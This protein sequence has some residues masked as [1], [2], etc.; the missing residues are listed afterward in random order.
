MPDSG[1]ASPDHP[2]AASA[3]RWQATEVTMQA[4]QIRH[5]AE[6]APGSR[7]APT[8]DPA[9]VM[10]QPVEGVDAGGPRRRLLV[11]SAVTLLAALALA[12]AIVVASLVSAPADPPPPPKPPMQFGTSVGHA[13]PE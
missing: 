12:L 10:E 1:S 2:E 11:W 4:N 6:S 5:P 3:T 9:E 8:T 7:H 13:R